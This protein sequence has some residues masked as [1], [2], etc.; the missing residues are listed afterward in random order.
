MPASALSASW[1]R[2]A[3]RRSCS[4]S[5]PI[6]LRRLATVSTTW[7]TSALSLARTRVMFS[8]E[9]GSTLPTMSGS[10]SASSSSTGTSSG[11]RKRG[12]PVEEYPVLQLLLPGNAAADHYALGGSRP[13]VILGQKTPQS[14]QPVGFGLGQ[15]LR[16]ASLFGMALPRA[17]R[18]QVRQHDLEL[19][20][21]SEPLGRHPGAGNG[22]P[23]STAA[24]I[25]S[26]STRCS[27]IASAR[28]QARHGAR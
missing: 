5:A 2:C 14:G 7:I 25:A 26:A 12:S 16:P 15:P 18:R 1:R 21:G 28:H 13:A 11:R 10:R 19:G 4:L 8:G 9:S 20:H 3:R 6:S 17:D 27:A 22:R 23:A 24:I